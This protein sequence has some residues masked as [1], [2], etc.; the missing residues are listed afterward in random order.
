VYREK[1]PVYRAVAERLAADACFPGARLFVWGWAP[2][3]YYEAGLRG[4]RPAARF[5]VLAQ[6][7]LT[8]YVPGNPDEPRPRA[9][10]G[11][12]Q[13]AHWDWLMADLGR[14]PPTYVLDTAP[15]GIYHWD[16]FPLGDYPPL[17]RLIA[18]SYERI[19]EVA[20]VSIYRRRACAARV[21]EGRR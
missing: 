18:G 1:D 2:A 14:T 3:F 13:A 6:A 15:A 10:G 12:V 7:G 21:E 11:P 20:R 19:G 16:R 5:A 8:D 4:A 9:P 17:D